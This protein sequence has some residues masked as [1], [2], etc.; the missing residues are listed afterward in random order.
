MK[1]KIIGFVGSVKIDS[2]FIIGI[3][4]GIAL[5]MILILSSE[6]NIY[7]FLMFLV[8]AIMLL[9]L[10]P[11]VNL[12]FILSFCPIIFLSAPKDRLDVAISFLIFLLINY[13]LHNKKA[14]V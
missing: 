6:W 8:W 11:R 9:L 12:G 14:P 2:N 10:N 7:F 13:L 3:L 5:S 1:N 4:A